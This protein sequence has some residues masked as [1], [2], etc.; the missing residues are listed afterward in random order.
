MKISCVI[1]TRNS[2]GLLP[3]TLDGFL[4]QDSEAFEIV[5]VDGG[6]TDGT[7]DVIR[8]YEP[9]FSGRLLW[10]SEPD[11]G[12]YD[13]M[14]KGIRMATGE[15]VNVIGAGD[16]LDPETISVA[17]TLLDECPGVGAIYGKTSVWSRDRRTSSVVWS[18]PSD[19]PMLPMQHPSLLYRKDLHDRFGPYDERFPIAADYLFCLRAFHDGRVSV[20]VS[21]RVFS[22]FVMDGASSS[23]PW[24]RMIENARAR[25]EVG[26]PGRLIG[27]FRAY[28]KSRLVS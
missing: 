27:D 4:A 18:S 14:N 2:S 9:R 20:A 19:L 22:N 28:A 6:S 24:R 8:S 3:V 21:D 25:R 1:C 11:H 15:Y 7:V 17:T 5:I 26:L 12:I 16:W 23:H 10:V 13:A